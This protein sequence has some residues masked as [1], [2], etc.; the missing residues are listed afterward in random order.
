MA[1]R[2][3]FTLLELMISVLLISLMVFFISQ[4]ESVLRSAADTMQR[5]NEAQQ[6]R[7]KVLDLLVADLLQAQRVSV[8][9][10][11]EYDQLYLHGTRHSLYGR[12]KAEVVYLVRKPEQTLMRLES[13]E[14]ITLPIPSGRLTQTH[15]LLITEALTSFKVYIAKEEARC[16]ALLYI[17]RREEELPLLLELGLLNHDA[18]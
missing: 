3:G 14:A 2:R 5:A 9:S 11:R 17:D 12:P 13:A 16:S 1:R 15:H 8:L 18:C 4:G 6:S 10:G 7:Q